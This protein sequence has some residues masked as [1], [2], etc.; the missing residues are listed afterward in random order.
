M[1]P[2]TIVK[3]H[4]EGFLSV[5]TEAGSRLHI[6]VLLFWESPSLRDVREEDDAINVAR[7]SSREC[8]DF[9]NVSA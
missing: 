2:V 3:S 6:V 5:V 7:Q 9:L 1:E 8:D 4:H